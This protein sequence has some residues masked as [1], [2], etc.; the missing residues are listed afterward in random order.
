[1]TSPSRDPHRKCGPC[2]FNGRLRYHYI[3]KCQNANELRSQVPPRYLL[4]IFLRRPLLALGFDSYWIVVSVPYMCKPFRFSFYLFFLVRYSKFSPSTSSA[5]V[6]LH[7]FH[8]QP[9][10]L[11][12]VQV[13]FAWFVRGCCSGESLVRLLPGESLF[14]YCRVPF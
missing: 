1:M 9:R 6:V 10:K 14:S 5:F 12:S 4:S 7:C 13:Q 2:C 3:L 11:L 8:P